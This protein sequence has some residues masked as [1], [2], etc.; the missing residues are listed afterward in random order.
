MINYITSRCNISKEKIE[1]VFKCQQDYYRFTDEL[2]ELNVVTD[3]I[4]EF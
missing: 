3:M 4:E 2:L 1:E